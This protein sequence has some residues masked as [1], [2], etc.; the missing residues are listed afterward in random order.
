MLFKVLILAIL[1]GLFIGCG[2]GS[3]S[4]GKCLA[5]NNVTCPIEGI[6]DNNTGN[7]KIDFYSIEN[8]FS[9]SGGHFHISQSNVMANLS[10]DSTGIGKEI[11]YHNVPADKAGALYE[12]LDLSTYYTERE[13]PYVGV[14]GYCHAFYSNTD[15]LLPTDTVALVV[16]AQE[17]S[18]GCSDGCD[19]TLMLD[20]DNP[21][22]DINISKAIQIDDF[23]KVFSKDGDTNRKTVLN[24]IEASKGGVSMVK[25]TKWFYSPDITQK[26]SDI[27]IYVSQLKVHLP[28]A[29][30]P[31]G[32]GA[33]LNNDGLTYH[34]TKFGENATHISV[35]WS[36][37]ANSTNNTF[38]M[39]W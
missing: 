32:T 23:K 19:V 28:K 17:S 6:L 37:T 15:P 36:I 4:G 31:D 1:G 14:T 29:F 12:D 38:Y 39:N 20:G 8:N 2:G 11:T 27:D 16:F 30:E 35:D 9:L 5:T 13:C 21:T 24:N 26:S 10:L 34:F 18:D 22:Y 3:G 7:S 25:L 33:K